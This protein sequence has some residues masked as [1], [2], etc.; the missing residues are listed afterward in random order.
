[1]IG[2]QYNDPSHPD[3][4]PA[5]QRAMSLA[6]E[7]KHDVT[8]VYSGSQDAWSV[9]I[10]NDYYSRVLPTANNTLSEV[11]AATINHLEKL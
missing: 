1:M 7:K 10:G 4:V 11:M 5:L 6:K 3:Y 8:I 2:A 9:D